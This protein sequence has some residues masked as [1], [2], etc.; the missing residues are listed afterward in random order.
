LWFDDG[1]FSQIKSL[2]C[3]VAAGG[4]CEMNPFDGSSVSPGENNNSSGRAA[5]PS[6]DQTE[7]YR[8]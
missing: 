4:E 1:E 2:E 7:I 3:L 5:V 8:A 6:D